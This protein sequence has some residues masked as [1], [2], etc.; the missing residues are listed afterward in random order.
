MKLNI[1]PTKERHARY[2]ILEITLL[3]FASKCGRL[4][5]S[6]VQSSTIGLDA[7]SPIA[8]CSRTVRPRGE[9][10][11]EVTIYLRCSALMSINYD[12]C[13]VAR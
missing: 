11:H 7:T 13:S 12:P 6:Q 3:L 1:Y 10:K 9:Q 8:C 5:R 4:E 2:Y